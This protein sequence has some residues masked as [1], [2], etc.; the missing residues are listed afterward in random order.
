MHIYYGISVSRASI[1]YEGESKVLQ[2]FGNVQSGS[3]WCFCWGH[4]GDKP[5]WT[6]RCQAHLIFFKWYLLDLFPWLRTLSWNPQFYLTLSDNWSS[7]W[8]KFLEPS[9]FIN[10]CD[11]LHHHLLHNKCF[12]LLLRYY[13][14]VQTHKAKVPKLVYVAYSS[15]WITHRVKWCTTCQPTNYHNTTNYR[16]YLPQLELLWLHDIFA[17][18]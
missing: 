7:S 15:V 2:Y 1:S 17:T 5:H 14:L 12:C 4:E 11:Q 6:M 8:A 16:R 18:N 10:Y 9:A 13:G 3:S